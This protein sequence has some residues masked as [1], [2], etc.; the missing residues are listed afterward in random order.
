MISE[1]SL[2]LEQ[3]AA[4]EDYRK[5][6]GKRWKAQLRKAWETGHYNWDKDRICYLQQVRNLGRMRLLER[7][8]G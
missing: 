4:L 7:Y 1:N 5:A 6:K 8:R 2:N 3:R